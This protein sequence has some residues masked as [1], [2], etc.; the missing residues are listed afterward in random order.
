MPITVSLTAVE[1][2]LLERSFREALINR[3]HS[4]V[5]RALNQIENVRSDVSISGDKLE[6][7]L[8]ITSGLRKILLDA[9][10]ITKAD[11]DK[12]D[13]WMQEVIDKLPHT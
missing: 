11:K 7:I 5:Y 8:Q 4:P 6:S 10:A 1:V 3:V 12:I 13:G 2:A 9:G